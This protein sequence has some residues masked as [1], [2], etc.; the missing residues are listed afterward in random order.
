LVEA[1]RAAA[2]LE[3]ILLSGHFQ[4]ERILD[5]ASD[6]LSILLCA[7]NSRLPKNANMFGDVVLR[8]VDTFGEFRD[9]QSFIE[10]LADNL[11][12]SRIGERFQKIGAQSTFL[13]MRRMLH[14]SAGE[15]KISG[16]KT[17]NR[18]QKI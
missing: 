7:D 14:S 5:T 3:L 1:E 18:F 6:V 11:P 17:K 9:R 8:R 16:M 10:Q 15:V 13:G 4:A 12:A 2:Q